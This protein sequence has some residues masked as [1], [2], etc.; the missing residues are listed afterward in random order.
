MGNNNQ[1]ILISQ[2]STRPFCADNFEDGVFREIKEKALKK[3]H[4][5]L[6]N[7]VRKHC[8][9]FDLDYEMS[10]L[11]DENADLPAA[12]IKVRNNLNG[13]THLTYLLETPV[14]VS[15]NARLAPMRYFSAIESHFR[16]RLNADIRYT[17]LITKNPLNP[18]WFT[19]WTNK[20]PYSLDYLADFVR[21]NTT[22]EKNKTKAVSYGIGRNVNLFESLRLY[23][24]KHVLEFKRNSTISKW[25]A[26][27][28][29]QAVNINISE[30]AN[31]LLPY[32]E[33]KSTASSIAR[34]TWQN[35]NES[36]FSKIQ[37][38]RAKKKSI[39]TKAKILKALGEM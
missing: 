20:E 10:F 25:Y 18:E 39:K 12:H 36:N 35:F 33:L 29:I 8:M 38:E 16:D 30:N 37:S 23:A 24:Y 15:A 26:E 7:S 9:T 27:L 31:N 4:I 32:N 28:E 22:P 13:H 5:Q 6:N 1:Q 34:W 19:A 17:G 14:F 2:I 21:E 3:K 11:A